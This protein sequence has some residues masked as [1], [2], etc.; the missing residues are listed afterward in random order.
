[1]GSRRMDMKNKSL[2]RAVVR[3]GMIISFLNEGVTH[4]SYLEAYPCAS[5]LRRRKN[6]TV[7]MGV[8]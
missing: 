5:S 8:N 1:M 7:V 3:I 6:C 4:G 2:A